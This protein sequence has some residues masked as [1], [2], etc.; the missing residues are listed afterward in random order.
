MSLL[1]LCGSLLVNV[2]LESRA[3]PTA[4]AASFAANGPAATLH[5][6]ADAASLGGQPRGRLVV[7]A[8]TLL[9]C[10]SL[11]QRAAFRVT[12]CARPMASGEQ[13]LGA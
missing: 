10:H 2:L 9:A 12:A 6:L 3:V 1:T 4:T 8:T 11:S 7:V 5:N 13:V